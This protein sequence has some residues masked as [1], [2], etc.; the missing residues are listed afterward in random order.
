MSGEKLRHNNA[1]TIVASSCDEQ[2]DAVS[3]SLVGGLSVHSPE[4]KSHSLRV[5]NTCRRFSELLS[6]TGDERR[7]LIY[8]ATLHDIGKLYVDASILHKE[9]RL[10]TE[11]ATVMAAHP[12]QG[13][14]LAQ[15]SGFSR[16]VVEAI[17]HHHERWDGAG[18]PSQL[19]G[20]SIPLYARII[21]LTDAFDTIVS[22]RKYDPPRAV[23]VAVA[24]IE[25][26]AGTQFDPELAE[27]FLRYLHDQHKRVLARFNS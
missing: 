3:L 10:N 21:F 14:E 15:R 1:R 26:C 12:R 5:R 16:A 13:A 9:G 2:L 22:R 27:I 23:S 25:R 19:V 18:Y 8:A 17:Y 6:L 24:E 20:T 4:N 7:E 11:E